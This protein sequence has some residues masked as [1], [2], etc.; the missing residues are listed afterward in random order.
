MTSKKQF[1]P[2]PRSIHS[3]INT[4]QGEADEYTSGSNISVSASDSHKAA[5]L[6]ISNMYEKIKSRIIE[7][8]KSTA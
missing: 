3:W 8:K 6:S 4:Q 5:D 7:K 1:A 2:K